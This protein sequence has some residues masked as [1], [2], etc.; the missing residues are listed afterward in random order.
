MLHSAQLAP[1]SS[2]LVVG[3]KEARL[4]AQ[5]QTHVHPC[6]CQPQKTDKLRLAA[7]SRACCVRAGFFLRTFTFY[8]IQRRCQVRGEGWSLNRCCHLLEWHWTHTYTHTHTQT[9][10]HT[11]MH[12]AS[13]WKFDLTA[14]RHAVWI[15]LRPWQTHLTGYGAL[16]V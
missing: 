12:H 2:L 6:L 1:W 10:T 8:L 15:R 11:H 5:L 9:H 7:K 4:N 3:I 16:S 14:R 13:G